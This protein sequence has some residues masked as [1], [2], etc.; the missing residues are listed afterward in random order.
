MHGL[1]SGQCASCSAP[2][3][4]QVVDGADRYELCPGEH[5]GNPVVEVLKNGGPVTPYD[6]HFRFGVRKAQLLLA[7]G[8]LVQRFAC[9][10]AKL[11]CQDLI[12]SGGR[13]RGHYHEGF[14]RA[15][16]WR[17]NA[18][19]LHLEAQGG[20]KIGVGQQK[21]KAITALLPALNRWVADQEAG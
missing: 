8:D 11:G 13:A 19:W 6:R 1:L 10:G 7:A 12:F 16:G 9:D 15:P 17:I 4:R 3:K 20:V 18:P 5:R 14:E 21:A 2:R